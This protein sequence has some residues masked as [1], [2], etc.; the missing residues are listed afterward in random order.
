MKEFGQYGAIAS[1]KIMWPHTEEERSRQRN[2]GFVCFM[3]R[4][5]A[6]EAMDGLQG[7]D[8]LSYELCIGLYICTFV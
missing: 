7:K 6:Q 8:I 3:E 5:E 1:V 2:C 4:Q